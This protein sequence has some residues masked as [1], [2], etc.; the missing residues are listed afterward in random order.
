[1]AIR[2]GVFGAA[3]R[4]GRTV[5]AAVCDDPDLE[6]VAVVDPHHQGLDL[7]SVTGVDCDLH[8]AGDGGAMAQAGATVAVDFTDAAGARDNL[9]WCAEHGVHAVV[10]T[11]G[12]R[13]PRPRRAGCGLHREQLRRRPQ[14]RDRRRADDALRRARRPVVPDRGDRGA[15]PRPQGRRPLRDG[16]A[17]GAPHGRRVGRLG[18]RPDGRPRARRRPRRRGRRASRCT[19]CGCG[20]SSPTRRC[21]SARRASPSAS[22]TTPTTGARSCRACCSR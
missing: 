11:T 3:G 17:D 5:C 6:L 14:L 20:A 18:A 13:R 10:G 15:A 16:H 4:M 19:R 12:A 7:R 9:R 22:A 8:I 2:V 21:C 1:M